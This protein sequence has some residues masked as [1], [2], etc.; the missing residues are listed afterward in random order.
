MAGASFDWCAVAHWCPMKG[1][2]VCCGS[3]EHSIGKWLKNSSGFCA[4][5]SRATVWGNKLSVPLLPLAEKAEEED[6]Q[7]L[8]TVALESQLQTQ[9]NLP[10]AGSAITRG[11][12]HRERP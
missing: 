6:R 1:P 2:Q 12:G 7:L 5:V 11:K 9:K 8:Q 3:L 4:S 10:E